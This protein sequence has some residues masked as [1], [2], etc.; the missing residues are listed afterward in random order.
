MDYSNMNDAAI[1]E[2]C[3]RTAATYVATG[4]WEF[5]T[6][7]TPTQFQPEGTIHIRISDSPPQ[8]L[9][10]SESAKEQKKT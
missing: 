1:W 3:S 8:T 4:R 7:R 6:V 9:N 10:M 5:C 2:S